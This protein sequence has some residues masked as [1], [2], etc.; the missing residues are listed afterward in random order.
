MIGRLV[1]GFLLLYAVLRLDGIARFQGWLL[2][3]I[4]WTVYPVL[5]CACLLVLDEFRRHE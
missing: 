2:L 5:V 1:V 4:E 3:P